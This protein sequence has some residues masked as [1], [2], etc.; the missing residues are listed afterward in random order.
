MAGDE[1]TGNGDC[2]RYGLLSLAESWIA[3][4]HTDVCLIVLQLC[5]WGVAR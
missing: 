3:L 1:M 2:E 4:L 5:I